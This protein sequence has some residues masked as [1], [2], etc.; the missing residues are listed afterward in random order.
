MIVYPLFF[1]FPSFCYSLIVLSMV[2]LLAV[3]MVT[4]AGFSLKQLKMWGII[5]QKMAAGGGSPV[6]VLQ[7]SIHYASFF[8]FF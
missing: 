1:F 7:N 8:L 5:R 4:R 2:L 6:A 3:N